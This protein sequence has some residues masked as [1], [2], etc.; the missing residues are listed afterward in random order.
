MHENT[1]CS[2]GNRKMFSSCSEKLFKTHSAK[3]WN[4]LTVLNPGKCNFMLLESEGHGFD[5][6]VNWKTM[7]VATAGNTQGIYIDN[8]ITFC[9]C[10]QPLF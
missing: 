10:C 8:K 5:F 7:K 3:S 4:V 2:G 1:C 9:V 6:T